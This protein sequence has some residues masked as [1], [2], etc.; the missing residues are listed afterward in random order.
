MPSPGHDRR[1]FRTTNFEIVTIPILE[2][3][4]TEHANCRKVRALVRAPAGA[5]HF[6]VERVVVRFAAG[7]SRAD[8]Q[9][10]VDSGT[11]GL[12]PA[13][14]QPAPKLI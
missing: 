4:T 6:A 11:A 5:G 2:D 9:G 3:R 13:D 1:L 12:G 7:Y 10:G 14:P 8:R